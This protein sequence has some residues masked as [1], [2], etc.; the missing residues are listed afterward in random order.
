MIYAAVDAVWCK[1]TLYVYVL[2]LHK[3]QQDCEQNQLV[4][5]SH[6]ASQRG[7]RDKGQKYGKHI[8]D[9]SNKM[10]I[11]VYKTFIFIQKLFT[12]YFLFYCYIDLGVIVQTSKH[13]SIYPSI[14]SLVYSY[15]LTKQ[16][17]NTVDSFGWKM[18]G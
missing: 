8:Y 6:R 7:E 17:E 14:M 2:F 16:M 11:S 12:K 5:K 10:W 3:F 4:R 1:M 15:Y 13:L 18:W 9:S